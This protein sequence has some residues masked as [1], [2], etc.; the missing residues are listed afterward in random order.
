MMI[1]TEND[2]IANITL[3]AIL[4][5][6]FLLL[7]PSSWA[8]AFKESGDCS[9]CHTL[10]EKELVPILSKIGASGAKVLDIQMSPIKGMWEVALEGRGQRFLLYIDF[11]KQFIAQGRIIEHTTGVDRTR[12]RVAQLNE[13]KRVDVNRIPLQGALVVG[14]ESAPR[15]VIVFLDPD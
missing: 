5:F 7:L 13:A 2:R 15:K 10:A 9:K 4:L 1:H 3:L 11:S 8:H 6:A 12:E 14:K